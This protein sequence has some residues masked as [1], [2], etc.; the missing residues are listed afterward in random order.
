M[1]VISLKNNILLSIQKIVTEEAQDN[2][3]KV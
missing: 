2:G 1:Y 3:Q